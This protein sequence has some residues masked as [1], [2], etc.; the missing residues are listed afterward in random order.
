MKNS[1]KLSIGIMGNGVVGSTLL[2]WFPEA[3]CY[4]VD[5]SRRKNEIN[6]LEEKAEYIIIAVP[7]PF[8]L[9]KGEFDPSYVNE[10]IEQFSSSKVFIIKSTCVPGTTDWLQKKY[11]QHTFLINPEF[12]TEKTAQHDFLHPDMQILGYTEKSKHLAERVLAVLPKAPVSEIVP[13]KVAEAVKYFRNCFYATKVVFANQ[14]YDFCEK[15]GIDYDKVKDI[16][17]YDKMIGSNHLDIFHQ[18]GRG[19]GGKCLAKDLSAFTILSN[20]PLFVATNK[21]N[22]EYLKLSE[23]S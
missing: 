2:S 21:L 23:K 1:K 7:T 8:D 10:A 5:V 16:V 18:G 4:D 6:E 9:K 20:L 22:R 3:L 14:F 11:P 13:A 19:A 15:T 12:L 17:Q